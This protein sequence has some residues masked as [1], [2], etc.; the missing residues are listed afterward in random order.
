MKSFV[1]DLHIAARGLMRRPGYFAV[2]VLTLAL[3]IGG[4][5]AIFGVVNTILYRQL[6]FT[7]EQRIMRLHTGM[8][9]T[10]GA[11]TRVNILGAYVHDL[12]QGSTFDVVALRGDNVTI[13]GSGGPVSASLVHVSPG[14]LA[15]LGVQPAAGRYFRET[16]EKE[17]ASSRVA[18]ISNSLWKQRFQA[19]A[20]IGRHTLTME[21]QLYTAIGVFPPSFRFPYRA[22]VW[23]PETISPT[24]LQNDY[25]V[26]ARL[27]PGVTQQQFAGEIAEISRRL[28][29]EHVQFAGQH[30]TI[31]P[32]RESLI[33]EQDRTAITMLGLIAFLLLLAC[34]DVASLLLVRSVSRRKEFAL[35]SALGAEF[36]HHARAALAEATCIGTL[37]AGLG[38]LLAVTFSSYLAQLIPSNFTQQLAMDRITLDQRAAGYLA[39]MA[40][41]VILVCAAAPLLGYSDLSAYQQLKEVAATLAVSR[42]RR[43]VLDGLVVA[44]VALAL[45]FLVGAG[46]MIEN[47][48]RLV[49]QPLGVDSEHTL[50]I[51]TTLP[52]TRYLRREERTELARR[53]LAKVAVLP[54]V[55]AAGISSANPINLYSG[56]WSSRV[57]REGWSETESIVINDREIT[58]DLLR[59]LEIPLLRG[60]AF[61]DADNETSEPV[62]I[63][64]ARL[65]N[66]LWPGQDALGQRVRALGQRGGGVWRR[67]VGVAADVADAGDNRETWYLPYSQSSI[68]EG[69]LHLMVRSTHDVVSLSNAVASAIWS[70]DSELPLR[71]VSRL[72]HLYTSGFTRERTG[73]IAVS[74]FSGFGLLLAI[75]GTFGVM[76]FVMLQRTREIGVRLAL[77]ASPKNIR[78]M[79]LSSGARL[80]ALGS[81]LGLSVSLGVNRV[82]AANLPKVNHAEPAVFLVVL[83]AIA[84][85]TLVA[86]WAPA[87]L[88]SKV[89][90]MVVLR[91]E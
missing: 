53:L 45:V 16:E 25:A 2:V 54:G 18:I 50:T 33:G 32:A 28:R 31:T 56:T 17:G 61:T 82:I 44:Q 71:D 39:A 63:V 59:A 68:P 21:R 20:N 75:L 60:R 13:T 91:S 70:V 66:R 88:A 77:G 9:T 23:I 27:K 10:S 7:Q 87:K 14:W 46:L 24:D 51:A 55:S 69:D 58:P 36:R 47:F 42:S 37:G 3:G 8:L 64:S 89:D 85:A 72:D 15:V 73:A 74:V 11:E 43:K 67:V 35:R 76:S 22:D 41:L 83:L 38:L 48:R 1:H 57:Q 78:S 65:A 19:D 80:A 29:A 81:A 86:C 6:P 90:P 62:A 49:N 34:L 52:R 79:L 4:N 40:L 5:A 26:F 30:I 12:Q 84:L